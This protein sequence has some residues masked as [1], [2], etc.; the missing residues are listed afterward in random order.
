LQ[1]A[2]LDGKE[3][4]RVG[5]VN[6]C[7]AVTERPRMRDWGSTVHHDDERPLAAEEVD[8]K[9]EEGI[10]REGLIHIKERADPEGG[11]DRDQAGP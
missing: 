8:Q 6:L 3:G 9:L 10:E 11:L 4:V 5:D 7:Q 2:T 1:N